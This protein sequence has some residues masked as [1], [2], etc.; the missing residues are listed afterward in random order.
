ME[1]K[2]LQAV[3]NELA[4][5]EIQGSMMDLSEWAG[6][7]ATLEQRLDNERLLRAMVNVRKKDGVWLVTA[8][9]SACLIKNGIEFGKFKNFVNVFEQLR[10]KIIALA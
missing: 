8:S 10:T 7:I 4:T 6:F 2:H 1:L 3:I 9:M 5:V